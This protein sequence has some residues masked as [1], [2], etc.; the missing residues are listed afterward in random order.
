MPAKLSTSGREADLQPLPP[1]AR[2]AGFKLRD[3]HGRPVETDALRCVR[4]VLLSKAG[5]RSPSEKNCSPCT[6]S[7]P[8][9]LSHGVHGTPQAI[10]PATTIHHRQAAATQ[11]GAC[12]FNIT[13]VRSGENRYVDRR[14]TQTGTQMPEL[15]T[16][17]EVA[18]LIRRSEETLRY[19]RHLGKGGPP[20]F[21]AGRLV[22][23]RA[24]SVLAWLNDLESREHGRAIEPRRDGRRIKRRPSPNSHRSPS[25]G[26]P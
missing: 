4:D 24:E 9:D 17:P 10:S 18:V 23:Y 7:V 15:L 6:V 8:R 12:S 5:S 20:S 13:T 14:R 25:Q 22:V 1:S 3:R 19:W 2:S 11:D 21:R 16:L 26:P